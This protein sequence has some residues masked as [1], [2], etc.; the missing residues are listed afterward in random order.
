MH[1]ND[2]PQFS[3]KKIIFGIL[4]VVIAIVVLTCATSLVETVNK[5]EY[6]V[7]QRPV[8]GKM[9]AKMEP[10]MY[11]QMFSNVYEWPKSETFFFTS[12]SE[13]GAAHDQSIEVRFVDGSVAKISGTCRVL[14][15]TSGEDA[16]HL[17]TD[18]NFKDYND[19]E[20][21]LIL[22]VIR[23]CMRLTANLMT[24]RES[25]AEKRPD[26]IAWSWDQIQNGMY[27][28]SEKEEAVIDPLTGKETTRT[29]KVIKKDADGNELRE[30]DPLHGTGIR[31]A[32]FE[33]KQF[34]YEE[35]VRKQIAEQQENLMAIATARAEAE[36]AEQDAKTREAKGKANV[37]E[38]KYEQLKEKERAVIK[39]QQEK[40]VAETQAQKELEV[41]KLEKLAAEQ[42][43]QKQILLGQGEAE[44]KKLVM[45]ADGALKQKLD[46]WV[47]AQETW[48]SAFK[49]RKVPSVVMDGSGTGGTDNQFSTFMNMLNAKT[50]KDLSL[51]MS[52]KG[53]N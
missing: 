45:A 16:I 37:M 15:P 44:R 22:P 49:D 26:F 12:D 32:N 40:E 42:E 24:A 29:I 25:Y 36:R 14:L 23:N 39:A 5:G 34:V 33:I 3:K 2:V 50:A 46:A 13:E 4:F 10:G 20:A 48:A 52:V 53:Q 6:H 11:G 9:E 1:N 27:Q 47:K 51:D 19:L 41:A 30:K 28:V 31:L 7:I 43:K 18:M 21:R 17:M 8:T 35:K 38:V